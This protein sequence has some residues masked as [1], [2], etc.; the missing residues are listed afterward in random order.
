MSVTMS[1]GAVIEYVQD[2]QG[3]RIAKKVNGNIVEKYLWRDLTTLLA[4]YDSDDNLVQRFEYADDR[5]PYAVAMGGST[6]YLAYDQVGSLRLVVDESGAIVKQIDYDTFGNILVDSN[7]SFTIP[8]GF[9]GGLHDRDTG[10]VRFGHRDYIP[11]I[12]KWTAKDPILFAGGD[13][14]LYGYVQN[15]P[16]NFVDPEGEYLTA[17]AITGGIVMAYYAYTKWKDF[18][19]EAENQRQITED[20]LNDPTNQEKYCAMQKGP[21]KVLK[22]GVDAGLS[23]PGTSLTGPPPASRLDLIQ[24]GA[25]AIISNQASKTTEK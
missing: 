18:I 10:L 15:D 13:T 7:P 20:Y 21:Y 24:G 17:L 3:R 12:G 1:D 22:K 6:Y 9:A 25:N 19:N 8:F 16:V 23:I 4:V 14:N 5:V 2:P 11:E